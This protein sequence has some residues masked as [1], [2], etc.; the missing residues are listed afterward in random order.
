MITASLRYAACALAITLL[1]AC[2]RTPEPAAE[3]AAATA[4]AAEAQA[5]APAISPEHAAAL[6][7]FI[8]KSGGQC[9]E[10]VNVQGD[11]LSNKVKVTCTAQPGDAGT[12]SYT[13][14]LATEQVQKDS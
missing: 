12:V 11:D 9:A 1:P 7:G 6:Q 10:I 14:D 13:V 8:A 3:S 5:S 2:S 4:A